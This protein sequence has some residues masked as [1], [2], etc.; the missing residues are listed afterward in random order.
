MRTFVILGNRAT[1]SGDFS[2]NDLCSGTGR[3]DVLLR[4]INAAFFLSHG[5]RKDTH[6]LLVHRGPP[7]P[8]RTIRMNGTELMHLNPDE[9]STA[10]LIKNAL[11]LRVP[12]GLE[13]Q[14]SEGIYISRKD[15]ADVLQDFD[16]EKVVYLHE[17]GADIRTENIAMEDRIFVLGDDQGLDPKDEDL[18][19]GCKRISLGPKILHAHQCITIL[20]NELDR[21]AIPN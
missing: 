16:K 4:C 20:H 17:G 15:L 9:R 8:P 1:T 21:R 12:K 10:A 5:L 6:L 13:K 3:L 19:S 18:L 14:A 11:S 2:L 7:D